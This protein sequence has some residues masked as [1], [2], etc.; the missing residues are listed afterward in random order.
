MGLEYCWICQGKEVCAGQND[1][2]APEQCQTDVL[3]DREY[4]I[5]G[6]FQ[7]H[8]VSN[9][10]LP[11]GVQTDGVVYAG[12]FEYYNYNRTDDDDDEEFC[13]NFMNGPNS[14]WPESNTF[15][16]Q[17]LCDWW[18]DVEQDL[19]DQNLQVP[20]DRCQ[21]PFCIDQ[22]DAKAVKDNYEKCLKIQ[23]EGLNTA[24]NAAN[25]FNSPYP[26]T[27]YDAS[28]LYPNAGLFS[29]DSGDNDE[30]E[31]ASQDSRR[32]LRQ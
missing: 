31:S 21:L 11:C 18:N 16:A 7:T 8:D 19:K 27:Q 32:N 23:N 15:L 3:P 13:G 5:E 10:R 28:L 24:A 1:T 22:T 20:A 9:K 2:F 25:I 26:D 30:S 12:P 17:S 4:P 14:Y 6:G 29:D